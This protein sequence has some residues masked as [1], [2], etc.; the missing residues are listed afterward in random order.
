MY[1]TRG[2]PAGIDVLLRSN[3]HGSPLVTQLQELG[4]RCHCTTDTDADLD[5][6]ICPAT[7]CGLVYI[8]ENE[9]AMFTAQDVARLLPS[10]ELVLK[11]KNRAAVVVLTPLHQKNFTLLQQAMANFRVPVIAVESVVEAAKFVK[12]M[13][14]KERNHVSQASG[15]P[16]YDDA[17]K[18]TVM[19]IPE[20]GPKRAMLLLS[21]TSSLL[22]VAEAS[23]AELQQAVGDSAARHVRSFFQTSL[24]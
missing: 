5:V 18:E 17:L 8:P 9:L 1:N 22:Q 21:H 7:G 13:R 19:S 15:A 6:S 3:L 24:G 20:L 10:L 4:L 14:S 2:M 23:E 12:T 16:L 11:Y